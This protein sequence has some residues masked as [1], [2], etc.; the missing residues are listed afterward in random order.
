MYTSVDFSS[1][2]TVVSSLVVAIYIPKE[3]HISYVDEKYVKIKIKKNCKF[4]KQRH[5]INISIPKNP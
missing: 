3:N 1:Q 2:I 5:F 4:S